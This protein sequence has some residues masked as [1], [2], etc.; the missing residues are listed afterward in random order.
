MNPFVSR[1]PIEDREDWIGRTDIFDT[2]ES[3]ILQRVNTCVYGVQGVGKTSFLKCFFSFPYC[4]EMAVKHKILMYEADISTHKSS[5]D[6]RNYLADRLS[7]SVRQ[8]LEGTDNLPSIMNDLNKEKD[9]L[10]RFQ[11]M[12]QTL[13]QYGYFI[14]LVMDHFELFTSSPTITMDHHEALRSLI[15]GGQ[16][17]C[18]AATNCDLTKDSLPRNVRGSYLLQKFTLAGSILLTG[19]TEEGSV[20]FIQKKQRDSKIQLSEKVIKSLYR[21]SGGIPWLL[22]A[23]AEQAYNNVDKAGNILDGQL[24]TTEAYNACIPIIKSWCKYLTPAQVEVLQLLADSITDPKESAVMDF[25]GAGDDLRKA[26]NTLKKRGILKQAEYTDEYGN[27]RK[28]PDYE[29][30]FNSRMLQR[31]CMEGEA[32]KAAEDNPLSAGSTE[33]APAQTV[34]IGNYYGAGARDERTNIT[35]E[36]V[37]IIQ[38]F[39][40]SQWI[41]LLNG[42]G[43]T[44]EMF[45]ERLAEHIKKCLSNVTPPSLTQSAGVGEEEFAY[46]Y[47]VEFDKF[48]QQV[49]QDVEVDEEQELI[50]VTPS[51]LQTLDD[52]FHEARRR[53]KNREALTDDLLEKLNERCQF[54]L[55]LALVVE[56]ALDYLRTFPIDDLSPQL[57][58]YCKALE[59]ALR[60][61]FF[62]L[63][64]N[65]DELS[66]YD[67]VRHCTDAS[68]KNAF[69]NKNIKDTYIGNYAYLIGEKADRLG[70]LCEEYNIRLEKEQTPTSWGDWWYAV[71][72]DIHKARTIRN[73]LHPAEA[74]T[75]KDNIDTLCKLL[76]GDDS[77]SG[78]LECTTIG[79]D[80]F[81]MEYSLQIPI[82]VSQR[83]IGTICDIRCTLRKKNGGIKGI[84][85]EDGYPVNVSPK[86][87]QQYLAGHSET[88][89]QPVGRDFKVRILEYKF[90]DGQAFFGAEILEMLPAGEQ[91][92]R[93][94]MV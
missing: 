42:P 25:T 15:E 18:V 35:A 91:A 88:V 81:K 37:A 85:C 10:A 19:L 84:T 7:Y 6:I 31:F 66:S 71:H 89:F 27:H 55:K 53:Y 68:S 80:L 46:Q 38:G 28:G 90:Q 78:I 9:N 22:V 32:K 67:T 50:D 79:R 17:L 69:R 49:V 93:Y 64:K 8:L 63:F 43:D 20:A 77:H 2:L 83:A 60:D 3:N 30:C 21:M 41:G 58:L 59:Q 11:N 51:E 73:G 36:H 72:D 70:Q 4:K 74:L 44:R 61:G 16:L 65:D 23:A 48:G 82:D 47:D 24:V 87:V 40:P 45:S 86:K 12:I 33:P 13:H 57:V 92:A 14:V 75:G 62:G 29:V 56:D 54:Y 34:Y 1:W 94:T 39:T 52:R 76:L 5:E 26:V